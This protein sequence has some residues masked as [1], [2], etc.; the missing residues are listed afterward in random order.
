MSLRARIFDTTGAHWPFWALL[1]AV[2]V[3][4]GTPLLA[5]GVALVVLAMATAA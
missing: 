2:L 4:V 5:G 3:I 1:A